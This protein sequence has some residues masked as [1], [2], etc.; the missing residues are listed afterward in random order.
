MSEW[1]YDICAHVALNAQPSPGAMQVL[2]DAGIVGPLG[3]IARLL[4][5]PVVRRR[6]IGRALL[7]TARSEPV[8]QHRIP[9][10]E[11]VESSRRRHRAAPPLWLGSSSGE[12]H[13][14]FRTGTSYGGSS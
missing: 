12:R 1:N 9:V 5:D 13:W 7:R 10:L 3:A 4:V 8:T 11:V 6:G 14:R 2:H